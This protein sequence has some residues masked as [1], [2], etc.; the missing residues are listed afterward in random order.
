MV[1][2]VPQ[3]WLRLPGY[4]LRAMND[5][6]PAVQAEESF[7]LAE[8]SMLPHIKKNDYQKLTREWERHIDFTPQIGKPKNRD[9]FL[10]LM[11]TA[12]IGVEIIPTEK[13]NV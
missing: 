12:Q 13:P 7:R 3:V 4:L 2:A 11:A 1:R 9:E 10:A 8:I 6:I 5:A